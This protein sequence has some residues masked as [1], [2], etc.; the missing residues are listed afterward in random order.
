MWTVVLLPE[1]ERELRVLPVPVR[2]E[3]LAQ[4]GV[5]ERFGPMTGRPR[6]DTLNGS[7]YVNMKELRFDAA[8]GVWRVAF[9]FDPRRQAVLLT[10]GDKSGASEAKFYRRLIARADARF[11]AHLAALKGKREQ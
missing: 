2:R 8:G 5:L 11:S 3:L 9:A 1:F 7:R 6:V 4:A 10:A